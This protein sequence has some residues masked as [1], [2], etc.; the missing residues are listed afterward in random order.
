MGHV[1][2]KRKMRNINI[3]FRYENLMKRNHF[4]YLEINSAH[5][6][7][8]SSLDNFKVDQHRVQSQPL[9]K[10]CVKL[11]SLLKTLSLVAV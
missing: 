4:R 2:R 3:K 11:L 8:E 7:R 9:A 10:H 5:T 1:A 6:G